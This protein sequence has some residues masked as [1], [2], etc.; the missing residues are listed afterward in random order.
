MGD[1]V[2]VSLLVFMEG[3]IPNFDI[4]STLTYRSESFHEQK[5]VSSADECGQTYNSVSGHTDSPPLAHWLLEN[6]TALKSLPLLVT[7]DL[8]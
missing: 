4:G 3:K 5:D 1:I 6:I 8:S 7:G 2:L